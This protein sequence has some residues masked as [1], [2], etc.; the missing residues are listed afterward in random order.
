MKHT[1]GCAVNSCAGSSLWLLPLFVCFVVPYERPGHV[2]APQISMAPNQAEAVVARV[3]RSIRL[4]D[5]G[6]VASPA[7]NSPAR[8]KPHTQNDRK[9]NFGAVG[10]PAL[11]RLQA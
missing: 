5:L 4:L 10:G 8:A 11:A 6:A 7:K 9:L 2:G 3:T 1:K